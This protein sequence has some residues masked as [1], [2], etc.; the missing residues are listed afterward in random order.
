MIQIELVLSG[1]TILVT[2]SNNESVRAKIT[3]DR[4]TIGTTSRVELTFE[5]SIPQNLR[6]YSFTISYAGVIIGKGILI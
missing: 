1:D 6:E 3:Y 5:R 2:F 4:I